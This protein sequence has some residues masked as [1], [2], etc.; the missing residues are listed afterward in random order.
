MSR[1]KTITFASTI[2][3]ELRTNENQEGEND[4]NM[5]PTEKTIDY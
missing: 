5:T 2:N 3:F 1:L 4:E